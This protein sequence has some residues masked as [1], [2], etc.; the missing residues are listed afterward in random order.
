MA[1][2]LGGKSIL[3]FEPWNPAVRVFGALHMCLS[4]GRETPF[5][6]WRHDFLENHLLFSL[7]EPAS[8]LY[9]DYLNSKHGI[10]SCFFK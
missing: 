5:P 3:R 8:S 10:S 4:P 9:A 7:V 2:S 1:V 6:R